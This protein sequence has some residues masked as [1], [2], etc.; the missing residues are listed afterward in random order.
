MES[1]AD[2]VWE[3]ILPDD[4]QLGAFLGVPDDALDRFNDVDRGPRGLVVDLGR[5]AERECH[6][7]QGERLEHRLHRNFPY[8]Q[9]TLD[10][11]SSVRT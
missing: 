10:R 3:V 6:P 2:D 11:E 8:N 4:P 1:V 5:T 9:Q 7:E